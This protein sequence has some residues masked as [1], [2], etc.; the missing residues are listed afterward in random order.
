[1]PVTITK[2]ILETST[3][4]EVAKKKQEFL[5]LLVASN[6]FSTSS[7]GRELQGKLL[8]HPERE[9]GQFA[10]KIFFQNQFQEQKDID[11]F[12]SKFTPI[13]NQLDLTKNLG[14]QQLADFQ[15]LA[16]LTFP[17][18][19]NKSLTLNFQELEI[20]LQNLMKKIV[21]QVGYQT[22][23]FRDLTNYLLTTGLAS[24]IANYLA[25]LLIEQK[26]QAIIVQY[27]SRL[28]IW[29]M[30]LRKTVA[31]YLQETTSEQKKLIL[32]SLRNRAIIHHSENL[33]PEVDGDPLIDVLFSLLTNNDDQIIDSAFYI[34]S[35]A[36]DPLLPTILT[37]LN[38]VKISDEEKLGL[39][40]LQWQISS[41][42]EVATNLEQA[43]I[44]SN[45]CNL[46]FAMGLTELLTKKADLA[47]V[48]PDK[49]RSRRQEIRDYN[50]ENFAL[51]VP[52]VFSIIYPKPN[53]QLVQKY[54]TCTQNYLHHLTA[55]TLANYS[56]AFRAII[57]SAAK[58]QSGER[59][60]FWQLA[61]KARN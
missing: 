31:N 26:D 52:P 21:Q 47:P 22:S 17:Y 27:L 35:Q 48:V 38:K 59:K 54:T 39:L 49:G 45:G 23:T 25:T 15:R 46:H 51:M 33:T 36:K 7:E 34:L 12:V 6:Y 50:D 61:L 29:S 13:V 4:S 44:K 53:P 10:E 8:Q 3:N 11:Y 56:S 1:M 20:L 55:K 9:I 42:S 30:E 18:T 5:Y 24:G 14:W 16:Q 2:F 43:L 60:K 40:R 41:T 58:N 19:D 28:P 57:E 37:R 32:Q